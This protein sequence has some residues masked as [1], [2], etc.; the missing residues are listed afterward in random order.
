MRRHLV[1]YMTCALSL[2][3]LG[4]TA[5]QGDLDATWVG[6]DAQPE[7]G[8][9]PGEN[10]GVPGTP[11][12]MPPVITPI[13]VP[14]SKL[15]E[16][17]P[18]R[19]AGPYTVRRLSREQYLYTIGDV[20]GVQLNPNQI[21]LMP[22]EARTEGF[23]N[24]AFGLVV[25]SDHVIAYKSLAEAIVTDLPDPEA[26]IEAHTSCT[27]SGEERCEQEFITALGRVLFRRP[28]TERELTS[29]A[30]LFDVAQQES[31][32]FQD[33]AMLVTEAMLQ[34]PQFL[35]MLEDE[36]TQDQE[37]AIQGFEM[38]SRLAYFLWQSAPDAAL[39]EAAERGEL[40]TREGVLTQ[41]ERM[42][43]R[44]ELSERATERYVRD[45][46]ALD[47]LANTSRAD[48][49]ASTA[50]VLL[51]SAIASYQDHVWRQR[52]FLPDIFTS[53]SQMLTPELAEWYGLDTLD[54]GLQP[55]DL[56]ASQG[57]Q[58]ILTHP[59]V[60]TAMSDRDVGGMVARGLFIM[61]D[62]LCKTP[63]DPPADLDLS[64]FTNHL[65]EGSTQ[66]DYAESRLNEASCG[67]CHIQ[68]DPFAFGLERF[69]GTGRYSES[70][71][72]GRPLRQDGEMR[73][74]GEAKAYETTREFTLEFGHSRE[75]Q[76][77]LTQKHL[78]FAL[79][80]PIEPHHQ[81]AVQQVYL[82]FLHGGGTYESM[83]LAIVQ[84]DLFRTTSMQ[85]HP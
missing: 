65:E 32:G 69:D 57:R 58:G 53:T 50:R 43:A 55:Y 8:E 83:A 14:E 36:S 75:A 1:G 77:C 3:A 80:F 60:I 38:A 42:L 15:P 34:S 16:L 37:R 41:A 13:E 20:L 24:N 52:A 40:D 61:E 31:L 25:S 7:P 84:N 67:A 59:G 46:L 85:E 19:V 11:G 9:H 76:L 27:T 73:L 51:E 21:D 29:F 28:L 2:C 81:P 48:L 64:A 54:P 74:D 56:T 5:C 39:L 66:R 35:Y 72:Q 10:P 62:L 33:G 49:D 6:G 47:R 18:G 44:Q 79:G 12:T 30:V 70:S 63:F 17:M 22:E 26:F 23:K 4:A 78:Q 82:D 45:W 68:F 71:V